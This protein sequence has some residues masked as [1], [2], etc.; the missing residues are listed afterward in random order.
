MH[1]MR[2]GSCG[3]GVALFSHTKTLCNGHFT[4]GL[5]ESMTGIV[6]ARCNLPRPY[7]WLV[8]CQPATG[9]V[10][11]CAGRDARHFDWAFYGG[12]RPLVNSPDLTATQVILTPYVN[13]L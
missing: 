11:G 10:G 9:P 5:N 2:A 3:R 13:M 12:S 6:A 4:Y 1:V 8:N 7:S